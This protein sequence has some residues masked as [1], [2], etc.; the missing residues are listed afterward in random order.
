MRYGDKLFVSVSAVALAA[1]LQGCGSGDGNSLVANAKTYDLSE[2]LFPEETGMLAYQHYEA[3]KPEGEQEFRQLEKKNNVF[4]SVTNNETNVTITKSDENR[5][6]K[7]YTISTESIAVHEGI[8]ALDYHFVRHAKLKTN[9]VQENVIE[10]VEE[11]DQT[12][13]I[14]YA[15]KITDT[16]ES[17]RIE[18]IDEEY[19]DILH[20][21]CVQEQTVNVIFRGKK[22]TTI[23]KRIEENDYAKKSGLIYSEETICDAV[24][25]DDEHESAAGCTQNVYTILTFFAD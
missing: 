25:V 10:E 15:C 4:Y 1:V 16:N 20:V 13:R 11:N 14:T 23:T 3:E 21:Q 19:K 2:Y 6:Y 22:V 5:S 7:T 24:I 9:F 12:S 18:A 17:K 8:N